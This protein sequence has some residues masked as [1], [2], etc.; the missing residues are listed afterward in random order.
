MLGTRACKGVLLFCLLTL[1][2]CST[3]HTNQQKSWNDALLWRSLTQSSQQA[4]RDPQVWGTLLAAGLLQA[5]SLDDQVSEHLKDHT[6]LFGSQENAE[7]RSDDLRTLTS[8]SYLTTAVWG[9]EESIKSKA[10]RVGIQLATVQ[11]TRLLTTEL[12]GVSKRK[13]PHGGDNDSFPSG[14]TSRAAVQA[15]SNSRNLERLDLADSHKSAL[16]WSINGSAV[17]V[18][19]ARIEAGVHYPS[20]VLA[21]W[22][23]G[24]FMAHLGNGFLPEHSGLSLKPGI[25]TGQFS[26]QATWRY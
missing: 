22:A 20:D 11:A 25:S 16:K 10:Q 14:H 17:L 12:K 6:P 19:W 23:L 24:A 3:T 26:L 9:D 18:G 21:G 15:L 4:I 7:K 5:G 13:R 2:G 8:F 1:T